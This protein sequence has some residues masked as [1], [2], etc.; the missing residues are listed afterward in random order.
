MSKLHDIHKGMLLHAGRALYTR[1]FPTCLLILHEP[2]APLQH[3][4]PFTS[5]D[6]CYY[7]HLCALLHA[8]SN[9]WRAGHPAD[10]AERALEVAAAHIGAAPGDARPRHARC[11]ARA[12]RSALAGVLRVQ[13]G[14]ICSA[15]YL[16]L[17][18][19]ENSVKQT[20]ESAD[21]Y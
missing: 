20:A 11:V 2:D 21:P 1:C 19:Q 13:E 14:R 10:P 7:A 6:Q 18:S 3:A 16:G 5:A 15:S 17:Q 9:L 8:D 4:S 12:Q